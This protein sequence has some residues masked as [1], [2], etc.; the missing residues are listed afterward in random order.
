MLYVSLKGLNM[1][2][3]LFGNL[4][5]HNLP[6]LARTQLV[7]F[8]IWLSSP[9]SK[10]SFWWRQLITEL[11]SPP[12][13]CSLLLRPIGQQGKLIRQQAGT[14]GHQNNQQKFA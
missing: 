5:I 9:G 14:L 4:L 10:K 1:S 7:V 3:F 12:R 13:F 11:M 8:H 2:A 6:L